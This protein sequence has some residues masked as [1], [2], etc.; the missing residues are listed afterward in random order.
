MYVAELSVS[1]VK[2][3]AGAR[4]AD[5]RLTRPGGAHAGWTVL[6]GR[7]GAGKT[8]LLRAIALALAQCHLVK[9]LG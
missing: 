9:P 2:G 7:N 5:L 8:T 3:F 6:A 4:S 1:S